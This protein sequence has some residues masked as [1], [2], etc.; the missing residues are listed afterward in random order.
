MSGS[1]ANVGRAQ[2]VPLGLASGLPAWEGALGTCKLKRFW[3]RGF[4]PGFG[5]ILAE[6]WQTY[7]I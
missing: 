4:V 6:V 5:N 3:G 2:G 7:G 1:P